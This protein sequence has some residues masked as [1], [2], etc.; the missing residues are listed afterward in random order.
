MITETASITDKILPSPEKTVRQGNGSFFRSRNYLEKLW[1]QVPA[2]RN[3]L[4]RS[5]A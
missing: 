5:P 2:G 1:K 3:D 4:F